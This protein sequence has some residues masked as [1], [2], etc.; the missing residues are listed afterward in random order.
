MKV[1]VI[2]DDP[3][4]CHTVREIVADNGYEASCL[5]TATSAIAAIRRDHYDLVVLDIM[6]G[7]G[8]DGFDVLRETAGQR[9]CP[10]II[11]SAL[12]VKK[13]QD[14]ATALGATGFLS[15]PFNVRDLEL[16]MSR[17][18]DRHKMIGAT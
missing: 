5:Q 3:D 1:L 2:E 10:V 4:I 17:T 11:M 6:L 18:L 15:K 12:N 9:T 13:M 8:S 16:A 14:Y 7:G